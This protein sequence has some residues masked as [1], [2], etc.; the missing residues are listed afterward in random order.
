MK[1]NQTLYGILAFAPLVI[2]LLMM[3]FV[4]GMLADVM[5]HPTLHGGD[6]LP[7]TFLGIIF[8]SGITGTLIGIASLVMFLIHASK[9]AHIPDQ[10]RIVWILIIVLA[11]V[12]GSI[13]YYFVWIRREDELNAKARQVTDPSK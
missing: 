8:L 10:S 1:T 2:V 9:N 6:H 3:V 11:G 7:P 5:E 12:A 13:V 4:G